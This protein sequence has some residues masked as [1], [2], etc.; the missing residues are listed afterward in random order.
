M[1]TTWLAQLGIA[2]LNSAEDVFNITVDQ[3]PNILFEKEL[4][5]W[6]M[7]ARIGPCPRD[8]SQ[9]KWLVMLQINGPFSPMA[10]FHITVDT[11]GDILLWSRISE[12]E[13][14]L[15]LLNLR[16]QALLEYYTY[17]DNFLY[18]EESTEA[19]VTSRTMTGSF[20]FV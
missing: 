9:G 2:S 11:A 7:A 3:G 15:E 5:D 20:N 17:L 14:S 18:K 19:Q 12:S 8:L 10:P 13:I 16:Y 6:L 4:G 1:I